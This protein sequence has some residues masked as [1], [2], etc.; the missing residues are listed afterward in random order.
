MRSK[1]IRQFKPLEQ[2]HSLTRNNS[3]SNTSNAKF[4]TDF[5]PIFDNSP[6]KVNIIKILN[7]LYLIKKTNIC[8]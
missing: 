2:E 7:Y 1:S 4:N 8:L 3:S 5:E 6:A